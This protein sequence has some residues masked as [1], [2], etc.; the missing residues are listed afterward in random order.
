MSA[1]VLAAVS[2]LVWVGVM[3]AVLTLHRAQTGLLQMI[4]RMDESTHR[5]TR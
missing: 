1:L 4:E 5:D 3:V 2:V